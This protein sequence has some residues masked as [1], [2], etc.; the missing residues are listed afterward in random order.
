M[1]K[2]VIIITIISFGVACTKSVEN[3]PEVKKVKYYRIKQV[4]NDGNFQYTYVI[5]V[6]P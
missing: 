1:K 3:K 6:K 2:I 5:K 4:D